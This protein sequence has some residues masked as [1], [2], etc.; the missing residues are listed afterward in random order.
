MR[1][2]VNALGCGQRNSKRFGEA[3]ER[4]KNKK[5]K[6]TVASW[7]IHLPFCRKILILGA[8]DWCS[9]VEEGQNY[10]GSERKFVLAAVTDPRLGDADVN[11]NSAPLSSIS[12]TLLTDW[13]DR[14]I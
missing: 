2:Y 14:E 5:K 1:T 10:P 12:G 8:R 11:G 3:G 13:A 4:K 9:G 7:C 6:Q